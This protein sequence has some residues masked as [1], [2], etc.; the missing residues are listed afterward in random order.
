[1][2]KIKMR[3]FLEFFL[4]KVIIVKYI[5]KST[6]TKPLADVV[7]VVSANIPED[8]VKKRVDEYMKKE[9][10]EKYLVN[11]KKQRHKTIARKMLTKNTANSISIPKMVV[12]VAKKTIIEFGSVDWCIPK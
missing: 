8:V 2:A 11:I 5:N 4:S 6:I 1:M 3:I 10:L 7:H 9:V 12:T